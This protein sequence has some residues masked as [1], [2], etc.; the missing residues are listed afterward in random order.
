MQ[1][2][3]EPMR[4]IVN[5]LLVRDGTLLM[6]KRAPHRRA[7]PDCWSFPGGHVEAGESDVDALKR[8]LAEEIGIAV[9]DHRFL[10]SI[11]DPNVDDEEVVYHLHVVARWTGCPR[12]LDDE[13]S[14]MRWLSRGE[15]CDLADLALVEY[16]AL[17]ESLADIR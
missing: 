14:E 16:R 11:R 10:G 17:I 8:E 6:M 3:G 2:G 4:T 9:S 15:A 12:I 7:Y 1:A 13:H 5:G